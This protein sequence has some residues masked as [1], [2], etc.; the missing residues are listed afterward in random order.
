MVKHEAYFEPTLF[1]FG[2]H[3][4]FIWFKMFHQLASPPDHKASR[5]HNICSKH[6]DRQRAGILTG[7]R[8]SHK[9]GDRKLCTESH[10]IKVIWT[11]YGGA[12]V[13]QLLNTSDLNTVGILKASEC[14]IHG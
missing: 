3:W 2:Y 13:K 14:Y 12:D 4:S 9:P 6:K 11:Q 7:G 10:Y 5:S 1:Y 8:S